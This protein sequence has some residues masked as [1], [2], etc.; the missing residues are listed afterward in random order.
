MIGDKAMSE[1][2]LQLL[3]KGYSTSYDPK[4]NA[5][6]RVEFQSAAFR[7]GHSIVP[8]VIKRYLKHSLVI[9]DTNYI[10][11]ILIT[12]ITKIMNN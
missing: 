4:I 1:Y 6:P 12:D 10:F 7:F 3:D 2:G 9:T 8:D 5:E 11:T